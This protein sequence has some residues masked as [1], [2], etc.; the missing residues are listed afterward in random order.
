[1]VSREVSLFWDTPVPVE[2]TFECT[3]RRLRQLCA[4]HLELDRAFG[5]SIGWGVPGWGRI[6]GALPRPLAVGAL[7]VLDRCAALAPAVA[8][9]VYTIWRPRQLS[10]QRVEG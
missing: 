6:L 7:L 9:F 5:V 2:H 10:T 4:P 3:Y 8:D 1:M